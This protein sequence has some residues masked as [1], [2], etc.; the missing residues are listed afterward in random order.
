[1]LRQHGIFKTD[2]ELDAELEAESRA[3]GTW[4]TLENIVIHAL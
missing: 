3:R 4:P 2:E 1:M